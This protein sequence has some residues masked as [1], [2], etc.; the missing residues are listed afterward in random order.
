MDPACIFIMYIAPP[1][2]KKSSKLLIFML[3][4]SMQQQELHQQLVQSW[5]DILT[6]PYLLKSHAICV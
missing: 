1:K 2:K 4:E 5:F 3:Q 6:R